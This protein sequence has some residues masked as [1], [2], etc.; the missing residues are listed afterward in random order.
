[1]KKFLI[2]SCAGPDFPMR[3][4]GLSRKRQTNFCG[5]Q[6]PA[7][8]LFPLAPP[9]AGRIAVGLLPDFHRHQ[10]FPSWA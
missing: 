2:S 3:L 6:I 10:D 5:K 9:E 7:F 4:F 1:L 8:N